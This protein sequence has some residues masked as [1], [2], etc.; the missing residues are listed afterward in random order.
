MNFCFDA[1][2]IV[3]AEEGKSRVIDPREYQLSAARLY[4][5]ILISLLTTLFQPLYMNRAMIHVY[6]PTHEIETR[7]RVISDC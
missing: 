7:H 6:L 2:I 1:Q 4:E 5:Y 3:A